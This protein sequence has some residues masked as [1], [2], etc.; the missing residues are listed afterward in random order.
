L[1]VEPA[2]EGI[3]QAVSH[4]PERIDS[5]KDTTHHSVE[6]TTRESPESSALQSSTC[7]AI[8]HARAVALGNRRVS[9]GIHEVS[10]TVADGE[11]CRVSKAHAA[12]AVLDGGGYGV[13]RAV[14]WG[15]RKI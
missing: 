14:D 1:P 13:D 12:Q 15:Q 3:A 7:P 6:R 10:L 5:P 8:E 9:H 11:H 4:A 2:T